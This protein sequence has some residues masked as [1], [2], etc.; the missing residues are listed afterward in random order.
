MDLLTCRC[1]GRENPVS[2]SSLERRKLEVAHGR[3]RTAAE[4]IYFFGLLGYTETHFAYA[5]LRR[6]LVLV[7]RN[8]RRLSTPR[9]VIAVT[10]LHLR[11]LWIRL[12]CCASL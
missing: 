10:Q 3:E 2:A 12:L 8:L 4:G 7:E 11:Y 6:A 9:L 5:L 1:N